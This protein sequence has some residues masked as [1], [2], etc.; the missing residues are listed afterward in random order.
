[1]SKPQQWKWVEGGGITGVAAILNDP[2]FLEA[3]PPNKTFPF[4]MSLTKDY[5]HLPT[6]PQLLK[7]FQHYVHQSITSQLSS[8][9]ALDECAADQEKI[10]RSSTA[11]R[12]EDIQ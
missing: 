12:S 3:A 7:S 5:W 4:S 1:M 10:L 11:Q 6:Y 9:L 8:E 2:K